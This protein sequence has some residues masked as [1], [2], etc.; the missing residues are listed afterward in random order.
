MSIR[1][2]YQEA[3]SLDTLAVVLEAARRRESVRLTGDGIDVDA[4][5]V[6]AR[7][8]DLHLRVSDPA[9]LAVGDLVCVECQD[10]WAP[11]RLYSEVRE[12]LG[13]NL[14]LAPPVAVERCNRRE[15]PRWDAPPDAWF[16][17]S[18]DNVAFPVVDV[19]FG[20][21]CLIDHAADSRL[22]DQARGALILPGLPR[23]PCDLDVR[24][25]TL[26]HGA[27][28]IGCRFTAMR[29][30][31]VARFRRALEALGDPRT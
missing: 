22:E 2:H 28:R 8:P 14:V 30:Q 26:R 9:T 31:D 3:P 13:E 1:P 24:H 11:L 19:G 6:F 7:G 17:R 27:L 5:L 15:S 25:L 21:L 16:V 23:F 29:L 10:A 12:A 18:T 20:G 4:Q